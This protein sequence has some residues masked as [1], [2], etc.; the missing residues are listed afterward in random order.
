MGVYARNHAQQLILDRASWGDKSKLSPRAQLLLLHIAGKPYV[1]NE[2]DSRKPKHGAVWNADNSARYTEGLGLKGRALGY[3]I[4]E[5]ITSMTVRDGEL[6]QGQLNAVKWA[7]N[8]AVKELMDFPLGLDGEGDHPVGFLRQTRDK[9]GN[10]IQ[11]MPGRTAEYELPFLRFPCSVCGFTKGDGSRGFDHWR[12]V[13]QKQR[14]EA[15]ENFGMDED[16]DGSW[17]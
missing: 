8:K 4:P 9:S 14:D 16:G 3:N 7:V 2:F 17:E 12:H 11:A 6:S 5:K 15:R 13:P 1:G 10:T